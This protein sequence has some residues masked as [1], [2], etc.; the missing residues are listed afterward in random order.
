VQTGYQLAVDYAANNATAYMG[1][2]LTAQNADTTWSI[3]VIGTD[4][5]LEGV[6]KIPTTTFTVTDRDADGLLLITAS[7]CAL[8]PSG[9][10]NTS[11]GK[12]YGIIPEQINISG[13]WVLDLYGIPLGSDVWQ[14]KY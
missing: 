14:I 6:F 8:V 13:F 1:Q 7:D 4:K 5:T 9:I 10:L 11:S 2:L 3:Y 12:Y